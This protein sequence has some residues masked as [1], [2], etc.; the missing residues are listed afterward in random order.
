M[1]NIIL[2]S[3]CLCLTCSCYDIRV[4]SIIINLNRHC[5]KSSYYPRQPL[6]S[7][8]TKHLE[9]PYCPEKRVSLSPSST[10]YFYPVL[11]WRGEGEDARVK[12]LR[13]H[14]VAGSSRWQV[15]GGFA[16]EDTGSEAATDTRAGAKLAPSPISA[17][18][19]PS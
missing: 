11:V 7:E 5:R 2:P 16:I 13:V 10:M 12:S 4:F 1:F 18:L 15:A 8:K 14:N 6:D 17:L 3:P 19:T 9:M